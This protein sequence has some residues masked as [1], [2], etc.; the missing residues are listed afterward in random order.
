MAK[1]KSVLNSFFEIVLEIRLIYLS[2]PHKFTCGQVV[3]SKFMLSKDSGQMDF[4]LISYPGI[5]VWH[6]QHYEELKQRFVNFYIFLPTP[7]T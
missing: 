3:L 7:V 6:D 1:Q 5:F 4:F 2:E